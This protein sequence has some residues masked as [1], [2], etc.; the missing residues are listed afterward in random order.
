MKRA[1]CLLGV[2]TVAVAQACGVDDGLFSDAGSGAGGETTTDPQPSA[3]SGGGDGGAPSSSSSGGAPS[4]SA[5]GGEA[6]TGTGGGGGGCA[7]DPCNAGAPLTSGC[8]D[9]V[10]QICAGDAFCCN[11]QW[12]ELCVDQVWTVCAK[13]CA[14]GEIACDAQ[15][16]GSPGYG[17]VCTQGADACQLSAN[18]TVASCN[19]I[20]EAGGGE[21]LDAYNDDGSGCGYSQFPQIGCNT[22]TLMSAVCVCSRGCGQGP[23]CSNNQDCI[24]GQCQ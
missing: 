3:S 10:T 22:S 5:T 11:D 8:D 14:P 7:H 16:Q 19:A 13:D 12:D 23:P 9:C 2:L 24:N 18:L 6:T 4:T 1:L 15:Y 21:C 17:A 20:C